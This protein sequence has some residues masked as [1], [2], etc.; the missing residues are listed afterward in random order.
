MCSGH[1][2]CKGSEAGLCLV[3]LS[4]GGGQ[5]GRSRESEGKREETRQGG[6]GQLGQDLVGHGKDLGFAL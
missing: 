5:C 6:A 2:L 3:G 1:S 4:T